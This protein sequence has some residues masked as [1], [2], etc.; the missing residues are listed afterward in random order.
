MMPIGRLSSDNMF[1]LSICRDFTSYNIII[2]LILRERKKKVKGKVVF[3]LF[4]EVHASH[5]M[6]T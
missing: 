6:V 2:L 3:L 5:M 4:L 1:V